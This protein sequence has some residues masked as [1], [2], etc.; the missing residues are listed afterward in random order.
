MKSR[1]SSFALG[2]LLAAV[3][4]SLISWRSQKSLRERLASD[5]LTQT[6]IQL[7]A[8]ASLSAE[9]RASIEAMFSKFANDGI[10][11][12]MASRLGSFKAVTAFYDLSSAGQSLDDYAA[13]TVLSFQST[14]EEVFSNRDLFLRLQPQLEGLKKEVDDFLALHPEV[15]KIVDEK[16]ANQVPEPTAASG[17][18]SS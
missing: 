3:I 7:K 13:D 5:P 14:L 10:Y 6:E 9:E 15:A 1:A 12:V 16:K 2:F 4:A 18:G 8:M 11:P 17:R